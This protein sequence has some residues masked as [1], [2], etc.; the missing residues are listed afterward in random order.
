MSLREK[1]ES[2][3]N[4]DT[5]ELKAAVAV[6]ENALQKV[7]E[8]SEQL[9]LPVYLDFVG[10]MVPNT[11]LAREDDYGVGFSAERLMEKLCDEEGIEF[12]DW[13]EEGSEEY[14]VLDEL[15]NKLTELVGSDYIS[16][17]DC[18]DT[19]RC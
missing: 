13:G 2:I 18:W 8:L 7:H 11:I 10:G 12:P 17:N 4:S 19:S 9:G 5:S 6:A 16:G 3:V 15:V 14:K 1:I